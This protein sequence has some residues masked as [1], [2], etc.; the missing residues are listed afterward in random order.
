MEAL[1]LTALSPAAAKALADSIALAD[2]AALVRDHAH[3]S[4]QL[5]RP[6]PEEALAALHDHAR[7]RPGHLID[8]LS[9]YTRL[10]KATV[11]F[12]RPPTEQGTLLI[13]DLEL[14]EDVVR[15]ALLKEV[16][17]HVVAVAAE[18]WEFAGWKGLRHT[19]P[20]LDVLPGRIDRVSPLF[21]KV[22]IR[23]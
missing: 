10:G 18:G 13:E 15:Q 16:P 8:H 1:L 17:L 12:E 19:S 9:A 7:Q 23:P 6:N 5:Q 2:H 21:R 3:W 22:T 11:T 14:R 4:S 20:V